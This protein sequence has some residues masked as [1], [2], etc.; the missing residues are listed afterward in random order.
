MYNL[1]QEMNDF[2]IEHVR[3]SYDE[4]KKLAGYRNTNL[5]RLKSGLDK[6]GEEDGNDYAHP[7][8]TRNQGSYAM[9]TIIQ[10]PDNDYDIDVALI[11]RK[12]DLP[13]TALEARKRIAAALQKG[14]GNFSRPPEA[15][16]HCATIWY[17]EGYHIDFAIYREYEDEYGVTVVEHAGTDWTPRDPMEITNWFNKEVWDRSP[18]GDMGAD[19]EAGQ[20]R[21]IVRLLKA[22]A[23]SR[24]PEK[25]PGGL[26]ISVLVAECYCPDSS[27]DDVS[28]YQTMVAIRNR[29]LF[30]LAIWNPVDNSQKLTS[31]TEYI[32]QVA[33]LRDALSEAIEHLQVLFEIGCTEPQAIGAWY[34][35][36]KHPFWSYTDRLIAETKRELFAKAQRLGTLELDVG[37][38][39]EEEGAVVR[40]HRSG[41]TIQKEWWLR[42]SIAQTSVGRPYN[43]RWTVKNHGSEAEAADDLGPRVDGD[44]QVEVQWEHAGYSGSHSMTCELHRNGVVLARA[45]HIVKIP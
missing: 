38:A 5:E 40:P 14:G 22:F 39:R 44:G 7:I 6:L 20:M 11:F 3:L 32:N 31:K 2:H 12:D 35:V 9:H 29:L 27:R 4:K 21:R 43:T 10:H 25:L 45:R 15:R 8:R 28:L 23:K 42:F 34:E 24:E 36:F 17:A 1:H 26:I 16:T 41:Q 37:V 18:S 13:S 30:N 33:R 19:V